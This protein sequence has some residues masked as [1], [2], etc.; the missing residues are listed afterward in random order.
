MP[1][2]EVAKACIRSMKRLI[3][4]LLMT[5]I[6]QDEMGSRLNVAL[7]G[8]GDM[9]DPARFNS[10]L[11]GSNKD[12]KRFRGIRMYLSA[13]LPDLPNRSV[14]ADCQ[15]V[16][17]KCHI[18]SHYCK[19]RNVHRTEEYTLTTYGKPGVDAWFS[20]P[21]L[22]LPYHLLSSLLCMSRRSIRSGNGRPD[23]MR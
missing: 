1:S 3:G 20:D 21:L 13:I 15:T 9:F 18:I 8:R 11:T 2:A 7:A 5:R 19:G 16:S 4:R 14:Y 12:S 22:V 10:F 6:L 17:G 23:R